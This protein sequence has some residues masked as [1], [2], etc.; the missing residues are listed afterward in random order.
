MDNYIFFDTFALSQ[1]TND[2]FDKVSGYLLL[3]DYSIVLTSMEL[4][5][6]YNPNPKGDDRINKIS[7]LLTAVP[8]VI[9]DQRKIMEAEEAAYPQTIKR[10][11]L[12]FSSKEI[13]NRLPNTYKKELLYKLFSV[14]LPEYGVNLKA[15]TEEHHIMKTSWEQSVNKIIDEATSRGVIN[16]KD[17]FLQSLDLRLCDN[18]LK[19]IDS[20]KN[21]SWVE[22][23]QSD[24]KKLHK[25]DQIL[26]K[27]D[28]WRM[29]GIHFSS[30]FFWYEY[31]KA[32]KKIS[33]SDQA[34]IYYSLMFPYC[35]AVIIDNSRY[36]CAI[37]I[38]S[39]EKRYN[40]P[41]FYNLSKFREELANH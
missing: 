27:H 30:L 37:K 4:V 12:E 5:E 3:K 41:I 13:F 8:F 21:K 2:Y 17:E 39:N 11:P 10:L 22:L 40:E 14:G 7:N 15:W 16:L 28:T 32:Q 20:L 6:L 36:D 34:D 19:T 26:N 24:K 18:I 25:I 23:N 38:Q 31:V 33:P 29:K 35:N 1:L 9:C